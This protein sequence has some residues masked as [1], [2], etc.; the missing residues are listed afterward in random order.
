MNASN[1]IAQLIDILERQ[2][3][4]DQHYVD[5]SND[6]LNFLFSEPCRSQTIRPHD[7]IAHSIP[8]DVKS[9]SSD[10]RPAGLVINDTGRV[11]PEKPSSHPADFGPVAR[12]SN[13]LATS[14]GQDISLDKLNSVVESCELCKLSGHR[15]H[16]VCGSGN[17]DADL[18]FIGDGP[19]SEDDKKGLPFVDTPGQLLNKI[20]DAMKFSREEVYLTNIV[21]CCPPGRRPPDDHEATTCLPYLDKEIEL[22]RPKVIVLLGSVPLK[23]VLGKHGIS[24][25]RGKWFKYH[26]IDCIATYH[27]S[28]LLRVPKA[29]REVWHDMQEVM[30][31]IEKGD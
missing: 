18:M 16:V 9:Q 14:M 7:K 17:P 19:S 20:I 29:K 26:D 11:N 21:K 12:M 3:M 24:K 5:L 2:S 27:P 4:H 15:S 10:I 13:S 31:K 28:Y 30:H 8:V 1:V 25:F 23:V 22:I 6:N